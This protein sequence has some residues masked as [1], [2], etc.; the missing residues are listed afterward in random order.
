MFYIV[1]DMQ[2]GMKKYCKH[3][4]FWYKNWRNIMPPGHFRA[5]EA[6]T[7]EC[8]NE[9]MLTEQEVH[10]ITVTQRSPDTGSG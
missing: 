9:H 6:S 8:P 1:T 7:G 5:D 10:P 2:I 4:R 3:T